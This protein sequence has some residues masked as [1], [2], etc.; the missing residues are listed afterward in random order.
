MSSNHFRIREST[1]GRDALTRLQGDRRYRLRSGEPRRRNL[2]E[3]AYGHTNR[4]D[5]TVVLSDDAKTASVKQRSGKPPLITIPTKEFD[6]V[7]T[8]L[9]DET[10]DRLVQYA[11]MLHEIAHV[12]YTDQDVVN[13]YL[14]KFAR[15]AANVHPAL[16]QLVKDIWNAIEDGA[17]EEFTRQDGNDR[18]ADRIATKNENLLVAAVEN[19]DERD[20]HNYTFDR[21]VVTACLDHAVHNRN[22][23]EKL[24]DEDCDEFQFANDSHRES[25]K[26]VYP[27]L[28]A[29]CRD[30]PT[31]PDCEERT[32]RI[33]DFV[34]TVLEVFESADDDQPDTNEMSGDSNLPDEFTDDTEN[35]MGD[36][37]QDTQRIQN[38]SQDEMESRMRRVVSPDVS[39]ADE[40]ESDDGDD[41]AAP[42]SSQPAPG[43]SD[44]GDRTGQSTD[45]SED[46]Q[47]GADDSSDQTPTGGDDEDDEAPNGSTDDSTG[48]DPEQGDG[49][50]SKPTDGAGEADDES[51]DAD[52]DIGNGTEA[53]DNDD[54][55]D[56]DDVGGDGTDV[57]GS[58]SGGD[59]DTE[60]EG[61]L[62]ED[63]GTG[64]TDAGDDDTDGNEDGNGSGTEDEVD[65]PAE[66]APGTQQ[67]LTNFGS[68][69]GGDDE[70]GDSDDDGDEADG[71]ATDEDD[72]GDSDET[73][74][75]GDDAGTSDDDT[76]ED[77]SENGD[78]EGA[79]DDGIDGE[80][81]VGE[82]PDGT[83]ESD[84]GGDDSDGADDGDSGDAP[85]SN[86]DDEV[87]S[88]TT[89]Q[90]DDDVGGD[91]GSDG[92]ADSDDS[93]AGDA[94]DD[95]QPGDVG[96]SGDDLPEPDMPPGTDD[97]DFE[98]SEDTLQA[99]RRE[100]GRENSDIEST[101]QELADEIDKYAEALEQNDSDGIEEI[102]FDVGGTDG[103]FDPDRWSEAD[104]N[105]TSVLSILEKN[106]EEE[107]EDDIVRGKR[108]GRLDNGRLHG[109]A[110]NQ[111]NIMEQRHEGE[112]KDYAVVL[113]LD[114]SGSMRG[115][116]IKV[117]E[118][119][120]ATYALALQ[121]LGIEVA[122]LDMCDNDARLI[123]PFGVPMEESKQSIMSKETGG[124]TPLSDAMNIARRRVEWM[125]QPTFVMVVT[126]GLP[127][128]EDTY[129]D[130]LEQCPVPVLGILLTLGADPHTVPDKL[131][132]QT[133]Y[134]D[135]F[136]HVVSE[137][138]LLQS[139]D[140]LSSD[141]AF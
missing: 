76:L 41:D 48:D 106:L 83:P 110:T 46:D 75:D 126:D 112:E 132:Q 65:D 25:F 59:A 92:D 60:P 118:N 136:T 19:L 141:I 113:V 128:D 81:D 115:E 10:F 122:L 108:R 57:D 22:V 72:E 100:L 28:K 88:D 16:A 73:G 138:D 49:D 1:S 29:T 117:A 4:D 44:D 38:P 54:D 123:S 36:G 13:D 12:K 47:S 51:D 34:E 17:I 52:E 26:A 21:A 109:A 78:T 8:E 3:Y 87:G 79:G 103:D 69:D 71:S 61:D 111:L 125:N 116:D 140:E 93:D 80:D 15:R 129:M 99:E 124:T 56:V 82:T 130:E 18:Q 91:T 14:R 45:D 74:S 31:M 84:D 5:I 33:F 97:D 70:T 63:N 89:D 127:D 135:E 120:V 23:C 133:A 32:G 55:S 134:Y 77:E 35:D 6:Q 107:Q 114:R 42:S 86:G 96:D 104:S 119:A 2:Q 11:L 62:N 94:S 50:D 66:D 139:L 40:D 20:K 64:S 137:R 27:E 30:A 24:L 68:D 43:D 121:E 37:Q 58:D 67:S 98:P 95:T 102:K 101:A 90:G 39:D 85:D 131:E 9:K 7:A 53:P 105:S